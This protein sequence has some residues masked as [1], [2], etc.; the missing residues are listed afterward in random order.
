[1]SVI[2]SSVT[3]AKKMLKLWGNSCPHKME[4]I[5]HPDSRNSALLSAA[6]ARV[7]RA[8]VSY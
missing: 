2:L 5:L 3:A 4:A 1:M 8:T 6:R 7:G